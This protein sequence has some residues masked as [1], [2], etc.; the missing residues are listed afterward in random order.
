MIMVFE[1]VY[2]MFLYFLLCPMLENG[3]EN[4]T[5]VVKWRGSGVG[6]THVCQLFGELGLLG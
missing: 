1:V 5:K 6:E 2:L 3:Y 4:G